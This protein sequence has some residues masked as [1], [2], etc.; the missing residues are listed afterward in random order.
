M[1]SIFIR[2]GICVVLFSSATNRL[3]P[4]PYDT[5]SAVIRLSFTF[6]TDTLWEELVN[7]E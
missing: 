7:K 2:V 3:P 5:L 4:T 6:I 1:A